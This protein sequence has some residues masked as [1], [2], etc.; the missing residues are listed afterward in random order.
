MPE[1]CI[2]AIKYSINPRINLSTKIITLS[3]TIFIFIFAQRQAIYLNVPKNWRGLNEKL[4]RFERTKQTG[5]SLRRYENS[6][7]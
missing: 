5:V 1:S 4:A 3:L 7:S 2:A 6:V